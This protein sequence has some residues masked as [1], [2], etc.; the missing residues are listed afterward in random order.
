MANDGTC[1]DKGVMWPS[2]R[3]GQSSLTASKER[4]EMGI[5]W[6]DEE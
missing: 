5:E 2:D 3:R 4:G 1:K 6:V